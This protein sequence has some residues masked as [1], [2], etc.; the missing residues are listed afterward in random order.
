MKKR[1]LT[2]ILL[3]STLM[4]S[5]ATTFVSCK[6]YD[7]DGV[8]D[9]IN[10]QVNKKFEEIIEQQKKDLADINNKLANIKQCGC[11]EAAMK[12]LIQKTIDENKAA[13]NKGAVDAVI[14]EL[15][16]E[17]S[18]LNDAIA[19]SE[20]VHKLLVEIYGENGDA[21]MKK[22]L[23]DLQSDFNSAKAGWTEKT[24]ALTDSVKM[25]LTL[26][27]AD[28]IRL[29]ELEEKVRN[30]TTDI[31]QLK[32]DYDKLNNVT[33]PKLSGD[34][35]QA[36]EDIITAKGVADEALQK[37][38]DLDRDLRALIE[39]TKNEIL[40][41]VANKYV[42]KADLENLTL[43]TINK[44]YENSGI[45]NRFT[46]IENNYKDL[47]ASL[48]DFYSKLVTGV[49]VQGSES[50]VTGY[51]QTPFGLEMSIMG[52][53]YGNTMESFEFGGQNYRSGT[54]ISDSDSNTGLIFV[55]VNPTNVDPNCIDFKLVDSQG[56]E[57]PF[58][59]TPVNT[60]RVLK[61][62]VS[63]GIN[64]N[65]KS[66]FY[67]L[68]VKLD[69]ADVDKAKTWTSADAADLKDAAKNVLGKLRHPKSSSLNIGDIASS[70]KN[71]FNNRLTRYGVK[72]TWKFKNEKGEW[73]TKSTV[74]GLNLAATAFKPLSYE[75]LKDGI[76]V[77][78]PRIP[79]LQS[80]I[81]FSDYKFNWTPIEGM[82]N[83][84]TSITLKGMP[85]L[86][87][88]QI[89]GS[90]VIPV[91]EVGIKFDGQVVHGTAD[92][93]GNVT[94]D[95]SQLKPETTVTFK[96]G[97][98]EIKINK[99]NFKITIPKDKTETYEVEI[100]MDEF[101]KIIDNINN[102]VGNMIGNVNN[103]VD[104]VQGWSDKI[105]G[106][107]ITRLNSYI[108]K[109]EHLLTKSNS[110][111]Q[112]TML[113]TA[114]NG[115]WNQLPNAKEAAAHLKL[116]GG[117]ASTVFVA[118]SYT[119]ELLAPAYKKYVHVNGP[120]G[121]TVTGTNINKVIDGNIYKIGFEANKPGTYE[122]VYE[123]V[124]YSGK[125]VKRTFY[126]KVVE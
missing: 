108:K 106:Q 51:V 90:V 99:D 17:N 37:A 28:S 79:S 14:A 116:N 59:L 46:T 3:V 76:N 42:S 6:D 40:E 92:S 52:A 26:A 24:Q 98:K 16:K 50:P 47:I 71:V 39:T 57:A 85:D 87:N 126:V 8:Y 64:V 96:D 29:D 13:L 78:L 91:P 10:D 109:F 100:P 73:V 123:A 48:T 119:G 82:G 41:E 34:L 107:V 115:S 31:D 122:I 32:D 117:K 86:D 72:A 61:F 101:N 112:P 120:E 67:A 1:S 83:M 49:V 53:Y 2:N 7:S 62:G 81:N 125:T 89:N 54:L 114:Q 95:L 113:Y 80:F 65:E 74:S 104:K 63:R 124:D 20:A 110:L 36:K 69:A 103:I 33:L 27:Q 35:E 56:N 70:I 66:G 19:K 93:N 84:K 68:Q 111:L 12:E 102:Q 25:A 55:T 75:F 60:D 43:G 38:N 4:L 105:D 5:G 44:W 9:D 15:L 118:T 77:D 58:K 30:N 45:D 11:T 121:A 94:V 23:D 21:G 18:A 88:I 22:Q 97:D